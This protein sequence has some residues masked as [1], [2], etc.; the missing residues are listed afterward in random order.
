MD[1]TPISFEPAGPV[2]LVV[3]CLQHV[4]EPHDVFVSIQLLPDIPGVKNFALFN[5]QRI[6]FNQQ[7]ER[8][9]EE[10]MQEYIN[11]AYES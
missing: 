6:G 3:V 8:Y 10:I 9:N 11:L 7:K 4:Q 1:E 2:V 5:Y